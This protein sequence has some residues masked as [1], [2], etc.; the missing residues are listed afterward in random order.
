MRTSTFLQALGAALVLVAAAPVRAQ[1]AGGARVEAYVHDSL[2]GGPLADATVQ[3]GS[4]TDLSFVRTARTD[5]TGRLAFTGLPAGRY[6]LGFMHRVLDEL[7]IDAPERELRVD[8]SGVHHVELAVPSP[9]RL[10]TA[11]CGPT[12]ATDSAAAIVGTV[13]SPIDQMP[14]ADAGVSAQWVEFTLGSGGI[15]QRAPRI[16][17]RTGASGWFALCGLPAGIVTVSV[18]GGSDSIPRL[19]FQ[20]AA[21]Q[22]LRRDLYL[23]APGRGELAGRVVTADS[24]R[25]LAGARVTVVG[26]PQGETTPTGDW[27]L[28]EVPLGTQLLEVRAVGYYPERLAVDVVAGSAPVVVALQTFGAVLDAIRVTAQ[29]TRAADLGGFEARQRRGGM[30]RFLSAEQILRRNVLETSDLL[31]NMPGFI[32]DGSL[33]MRSNFSD[34]AGNYGTDCTAEVYVDGHLMRG[35]STAELDALVKPE[36]IVGIEVYAPGSPRPPQFDSGL[37]GCGSLVIWQKPIGERVRRE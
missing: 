2:A 37:S 25:P 12:A 9:M 34:G 6:R 7:G 19:D 16:T 21:Q 20:L 35:I 31:R 1:Q 3:L 14:V 5:S 23:S 17:A 32:G 13:R 10:R 28:T 27:R 26:G 22:L 30:G 36:H 24:A 4:L 33:T 29:R 11:L 18:A 8:G 15:Q